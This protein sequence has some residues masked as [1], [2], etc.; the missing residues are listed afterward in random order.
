M[1]QGN[2]QNSTTL[3]AKIIE[4]EA[5]LI[6]WKNAAQK[7]ALTGCLRRE[8]LISILHERRSFGLLPR[9]MTLAIADLDHFKKVNDT[10]GHLSGDEVLRVFSKILQENLPL[11]SL[12]CRMGGEEFVILCPDP[13]RASIDN[14]NNIRSELQDVQ[15]GSR[16]IGT[17]NVSVSMGVANWNTDENILQAIGQ[18]DQALY[19]AK[20]TGRNK[21]AA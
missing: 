1:N 11:G 6:K 15:F 12:V 13:I 18:A 4:L 19:Q 7:D 20:N 3:E 14:L 21:I 5:E 8:A 16:T 9:Y 2:K 17:F 10:Y